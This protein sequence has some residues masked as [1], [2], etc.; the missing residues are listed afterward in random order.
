MERLE[1]LRNEWEVV[2]GRDGALK[3]CFGVETSWTL[4]SANL[5]VIPWSTERGARRE[6]SCRVLSVLSLLRA[7]FAC[8]D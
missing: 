5:C 7:H 8:G 3:D 6:A 2:Y 1:T 4:D